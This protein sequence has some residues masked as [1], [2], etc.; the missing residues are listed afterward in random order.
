MPSRIKS[1]SKYIPYLYN[2]LAGITVGSTFNIQSDTSSVLGPGTD[3]KISFASKFTSTDYVL[4]VS[5]YDANGVDTKHIRKSKE[6]D[7]FTID[8][9]FASIV[10]Y[11]AY[12]KL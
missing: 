10:E 9:P 3:I 12:Q 4:V 1:S 8:L 11:I 2:Q 5:T 7:G 6:L